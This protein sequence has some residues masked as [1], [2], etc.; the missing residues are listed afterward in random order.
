MMKRSTLAPRQLN[1][2]HV[3]AMFI[4]F[5]GVIIAVNTAL[6]VYASRSW[7]GLVVENSY[8]TSQRF[9]SLIERSREQ[10]ALGWKSKLVI[11]DGAI[12]YELADGAGM[13]VAL[14]GVTVKFRHPAYDSQDRT[15]ALREVGPGAFS[16]DHGV[17]DGLW[18]VEIDADAGLAQP[19]QE[20]SRM[21][22]A[23]GSVK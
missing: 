5:F 12:R 21:V 13:P 18:I 17:R 10:E 8:V 15:M 6:A 11:A 2:W 20:A 19:Y 23:G 14:R 9:N 1:G 3:L 4:A 16:L 22:I 7:T